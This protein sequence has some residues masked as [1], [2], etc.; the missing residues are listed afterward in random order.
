VHWP[1]GADHEE[2]AV[3]DAAALVPDLDD[4]PDLRGERGADIFQQTVYVRVV[5]GFW[6]GNAHA[7][8]LMEGLKEPFK[9]TSS[10][11]HMIAISLS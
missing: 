1:Q 3:G 11:C 10:S 4:R 9:M 8:D 5:G 2:S 7:V 6:Q